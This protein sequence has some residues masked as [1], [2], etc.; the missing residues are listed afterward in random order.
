MVVA[1]ASPYR[2]L[3]NDATPLAASAALPAFNPLDPAF[4]ADPYPF[5]ALLRQVAPVFKAPP[6]FWLVTRYADAHAVLRD[7]RFGKD[8]AGDMVQ[9]FG[10]EDCLKEPAIASAGRT[11][12]VLD[13]PDHTRLRSL[14][15]KAFTARRVA[16]MRPRIEALVA[17]QIDRVIDRGEMD[18][19]HDLAHRLP[20]IV[21]CDMLGIPEEQRGPFLEGSTVNT[22][23]LEPVPM[24]RAEL[25]AANL[26]TKLMAEYFDQLCALRRREPRDDL[27]TDLVRAEEAGDR[28]SP[29]ELQS[30]INLLFTAG[31]ET[32]VNLI[33][34]GLLALH[35]H[36]DQWERLK[37]DPSLLPNAVEEL[38]RYD[39]SVQLSVRVTREEVEIGGVAVPPGQ[40]VITLLG[41]ANRDPAQ[42]PDPD[43]LDVG[44]PDIRP[45]SF[46]GGIH[47]CLGAQLA[48]LE[49]ELVFAALIE[50]LPNLRL[51]E[52]DNPAWRQS[53]ALRGL[54]R[55]PATWH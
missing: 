26:N 45:L 41:A 35:R 40:S 37:A 38:L 20:V 17:R 21:I 43:R 31:H 23:I 52:K 28:L 22:R 34:N 30:N 32:T 8:F 14:V 13:P 49:G 16:D 3:M 39:S 9:R 6:G 29:E 47:H 46:G 18:V 4:I 33:G 42:Y 51:P 15:S 54:S 7:K 36:P 53:F 5:Y 50:R 1:R 11:M 55:L 10:S 19:I 24:S 2:L 48:R 27:T 25:D 12:L 44:R